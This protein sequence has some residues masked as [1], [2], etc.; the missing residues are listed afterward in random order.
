MNVIYFLLK[1]RQLLLKD[2]ILQSYKPR[3]YKVFSSEQL[4]KLHETFQKC[5]YPTK[6]RIEDLAKES[7]ET[8]ERIDNWFRA[9]RKKR[10]GLGKMSYEVNF[11]FFLKIQ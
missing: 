3:K 6:E 1:I 11:F 4:H 7:N 10:I 8:I 9:E 2:S 5:H